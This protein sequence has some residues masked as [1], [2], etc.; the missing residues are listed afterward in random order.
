MTNYP[1]GLKVVREAGKEGGFETG[2]GWFGANWTWTDRMFSV[3]VNTPGGMSGV[4]VM[5]NG[6]RHEVDGGEYK[7][8]VTM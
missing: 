6:E 7:F 8:E 4:V 1:L 5:P 3:G 2:L